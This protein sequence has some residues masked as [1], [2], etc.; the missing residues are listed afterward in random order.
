MRISEWIWTVTSIANWSW[1]PHQPAS[2]VKNTKPQ[3]MFHKDATSTKLEEKMCGL[4]AL[5]QQPNSRIA[6]RSWRQL[7]SSPKQPWSCSLWTLRRRRERSMEGVEKEGSDGEVLVIG[8]FFF[9]LF[10]EGFRPQWCICTIN[11]ARDTPFWSGTLVIYFFNVFF[12][13]FLILLF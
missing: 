11:H 12:L 8:F 6:G 9:P 5:P 10:I 3:S 4:S 1:H 7:H 2:V 13:F